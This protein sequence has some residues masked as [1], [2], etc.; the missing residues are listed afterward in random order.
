LWTYPERDFSEYRSILREPS[1]TRPLGLDLQKATEVLQR[2]GRRVVALQR[3]G[4]RVAELFDKY[5][6]E[7][8]GKDMACAPTVWNPH[9]TEFAHSFNVSFMYSVFG[10]PGCFFYQHRLTQATQW[11]KP[12][13][14]VPHKDVA[15]ASTEADGTGDNE[16]GWLPPIAGTQGQE[17]KEASY[18]G[19]TPQTRKYREDSYMNGESHQECMYVIRCPSLKILILV[20][21]IYTRVE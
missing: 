12:M 10:L 20:W 5:F 13:G 18:W 21:E 14:L 1:S 3:T 11:H 4:R 7:Q 17:T 9:T 6:D 16:G 8:S 15:M 2:F 19:R